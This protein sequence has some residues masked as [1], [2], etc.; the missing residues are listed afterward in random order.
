MQMEC[1]GHPY[2]KH[3]QLLGMAQGILVDN[4]NGIENCSHEQ[5]PFDS[6]MV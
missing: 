3:T 5:L 2:I 1:P 4:V 6:A